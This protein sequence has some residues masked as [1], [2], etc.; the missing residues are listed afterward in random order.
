MRGG[1]E[2]NLIPL[3]VLLEFILP[4]SGAG[5]KVVTQRGGGWGGGRGV[6]AWSLLTQAL[7][8]AHEPGPHLS[9]REGSER[10]YIHIQRP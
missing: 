7:L 8:R 1:R 2:S 10:S 5:S 6:M 4:L 9:L 3:F